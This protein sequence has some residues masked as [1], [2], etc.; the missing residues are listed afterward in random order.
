M[1]SHDEGVRTDKKQKQYTTKGATTHKRRQTKKR[2]FSG[3]LK[4]RNLHKDHCPLDK[5]NCSHK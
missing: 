3:S 2:M 1:V 4:R 5:Q